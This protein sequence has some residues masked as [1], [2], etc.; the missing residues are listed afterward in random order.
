[1]IRLIRKLKMR[2][3]KED[4]RTYYAP[5]KGKNCE[6]VSI[7]LHYD[8]FVGSKEHPD[9]VTELQ[10]ELDQFSLIRP[11]KYDIALVSECEESGSIVN[12]M[13][14]LKRD[15]SIE[16]WLPDGHEC[17]VRIEEHKPNIE[18]IIKTNSGIYNSIMLNSK[19]KESKVVGAELEIYYEVC[20]SHKNYGFIEDGDIFS[21]HDICPSGG[22]DRDLADNSSMHAVDITNALV[23]N[24]HFYSRELSFLE[25]KPFNPCIGIVMTEKEYG[26]LSKKGIE[27]CKVKFLDKRMRFYDARVNLDY[28]DPS[29]GIDISYMLKDG[30]CGPTQIQYRLGNSL[31]VEIMLNM[32]ITKDSYNDH[33]ILMWSITGD[34]GKTPVSLTYV[35]IDFYIYTEVILN[36]WE[37]VNHVGTVEED[38]DDDDDPDYYKKLEE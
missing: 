1:M 17:I 7:H 37:E 3:E 27:F 32:V 24:P 22:K 35:D 8:A 30:P 26:N 15:I 4:I 16:G 31:D 34:C 28:I 23:Q 6:S 18:I 5:Y 19:G 20:Y 36:D 33:I 9:M 12:K 13:A 21:V 10:K 2:F 14:N 38:D 25:I 29:E 11:L